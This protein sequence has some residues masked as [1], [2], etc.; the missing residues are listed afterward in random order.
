MPVDDGAELALK[1]LEKWACQHGVE[2]DFRDSGKRTEN[3]YI[4]LVNRR[5]L[6][7]FLNATQFLSMADCCARIEA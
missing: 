1:T 4:E 5:L 7:E 3:G 2:L 6:D